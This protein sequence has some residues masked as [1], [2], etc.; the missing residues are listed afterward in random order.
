MFNGRNLLIATKH[1][2]ERVIAPILEKELGLRCF[3][4][5]TLDTDKLG[6]FTGEIERKDDPITTAR[7]KCLM[8]MELANCDLALASEGSF[9][10]HPSIY[11]VP[12]DDEFLI[13][14][15]KKNDIEV[16]VRELSVDTNFNVAEIKTE[17][18]LKT[19]AE[20]AKFPSH[21]LIIRKSKD[22]YSKI[23]KGITN[24]ET[25]ISTFNHFISSHGTVY[26]ETDMRAMYNPMRMKIIEDAVKKLV[27]KLK[28]HCPECN[29]PGFSI[30]DIKT[31]L[32]CSICNFPTRSILSNLYSC[33]KCQFIHEE[34]FPKGKFTEDPMY[35]DVCNP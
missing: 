21:G 9:G 13:F 8:A 16:I 4:D 2:K 10:P 22:D 7:N 1:Q 6:T 12:A 20:N 23:V 26:I 27:V 29:T 3:I 11:F 18:E 35:C 25:L 17:K 24:A 28:S 33:Q 34:K 15:D 31:G 5:P 14:I 19:F 30:T 32:P